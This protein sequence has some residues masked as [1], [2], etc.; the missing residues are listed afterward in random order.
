MSLTWPI[1]GTSNSLVPFICS[2]LSTSSGGTL[3]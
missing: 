1:L 2:I 3:Y